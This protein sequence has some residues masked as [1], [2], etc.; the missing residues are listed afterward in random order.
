MTASIASERIDGFSRPPDASSPLP[1]ASAGPMPSSA[2]SSASTPALTTAARTLASSP[3]ASDVYVPKRWSVTTSPSTA[4]PR[5]SSRSLDSVP[6]FSA[7]H[8]RW[9]RA[10]VKR[11]SSWKWRPTRCRREASASC[12]VSSTALSE[13]GDHVVDG[14]AHRLQVLEVLVVDAEPHRPLAELLLQR[15]HELDQGERVGV[16]V[17]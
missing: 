7:H 14:I 17:L 5:N 13:A 6:G 9:A 15:F 8:E 10:K 12:S 2:A 1:R 3:S 16:E 4:S 11:A